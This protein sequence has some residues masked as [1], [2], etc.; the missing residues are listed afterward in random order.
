MWRIEK[1]GEFVA[2]LPVPGRD[3]YT[4]GRKDCDILITD[5]SVSRAHA[6]FTLEG[7]QLWVRDLGSKFG[8]KLAGESLSTERRR[9]CGDESLVFGMTELRPVA[10]PAFAFCCSG[11]PRKETD[12]IEPL[13]KHLGA[14]LHKDWDPSVTHVVMTHLR[15]TPKL[16]F[17]LASCIPIVTPRWL[18]LAASRTKPDTQLPEISGDDCVPLLGKGLPEM[19]Q[20]VRAE[21]TSL[22]HGK[23]FIWLTGGESVGQQ[24]EAQRQDQHQSRQ[25]TSTLLELMGAEPLS[26]LGGG[27]VASVKAQLEL[28]Y[29]FLLAEDVSPGTCEIVQLVQCA[30]GCI[31]T[32]SAV[33]LCLI[34]CSLEHLKRIEP[35]TPQDSGTAG[36]T[37]RPA[38]GQI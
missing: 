20:R 11:L 36:G 15:V 35:S 2:L 32:A 10:V 6:E 19:T 23:R 12:E 5:K 16:L 4:L 26:A 33:R 17:A 27:R 38:R 8:S 13:C 7:R 34:Y 24:P 18:K 29:E 25:Q 22:F 37:I 9:V 21:R 28:G 31:Y 14:K 1:N 30:G 3:K